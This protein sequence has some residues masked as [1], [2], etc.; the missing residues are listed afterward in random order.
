MNTLGLAEANRILD[1]CKE[2]NIRTIAGGPHATILPD[3]VHADYAHQGEGEA[4]MLALVTGNETNYIEN[5]D[6]LGH[7]A[8]DLVDMPKYLRAWHYLDHIS[9]RLTGTNILASRGC[10]WNCSYCQP[11]LRNIFG[12]KVRRHSPLWVSQEVN[13]LQDAYGVDGV[14]FHDDTFTADR[15]W[16]LEV[17]QRLKSLDI[18]WGC[19]V[20]ADTVDEPLLHK[21]FDAGLR[22][23][24]LGIECA[25]DRI[26]NEV[27]QKHITTDQIWEACTAAQASGV[28]VMGFFML[29]APQ[30]TE[31]EMEETVVLACRL[32]LTEAT[33]SI[34][35]AL[36][37]THLGNIGFASGAD[38]YGSDASSRMQALQH[39]A[40]CRFY[41][42]HKAY[43]A[44]HLLSWQG[45]ERL[46]RKIG[47][48]R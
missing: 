28:A 25:S 4:A 22:N 2:R 8:F 30:E 45:L 3:E 38:Y 15:E 5:L 19:N 39:S 21:M 36:P 47:R 18:L 29:G 32:P 9:P 42:K 40:L 11:T 23:I 37:G 1:W 27:Y 41:W 12:K 44:R 17:C 14:F 10:P 13:R 31:E 33:F 48:F 7:P 46:M 26:R 20:R 43:I 24:H 34:T 35:S 6:D 16:V